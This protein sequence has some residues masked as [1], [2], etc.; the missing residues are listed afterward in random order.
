[1]TPVKLAVVIPTFNERENVQPLLARL[2][3]ALA[4]IRHEVIFVDDDSPDGTAECIREIA[5]QRSDVRVVQ[6]IGRRGLGSACIEGMLASAAP[7]IAV[8]DADMQ[9]DERILPEMFRKLVGENLDLVVGS[10]NLETG[11][12]GEF[13]R[14]RVML[15]NAGRRLSAAATG[16]QMSDPMSGFFMLDRR[17]LDEVVHHAS[18]VG[19]K[20]LLDLVASARRPVRIGEVPYTFRNRLHGESKLDISVGLEYL[21]LLADKMIGH[22]IPVRFVMFSLVGA[23]GLGLYLLVLGGLYQ[24]LG[25]DFLESL[26]A[27]TFLAMTLNF[28][29][30]NSFTYRDMKLKGF[31]LVM[32]LALFYVAC[33]IGAVSNAQVAQSLLASSAPWWVAA[34][35]GLLISAV[36][37]YGVTSIFTWRIHQVRTEARVQAQSQAVKAAAARAAA[38]QG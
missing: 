11:G 12:M 6:R 35:V 36:W 10:R 31:R 34:T 32:G 8:M 27:A 9:H 38:G 5:R 22:I 15:S 18:G 2:D 26:L 19:F 7:Y 29:L 37:N 3:D 20:I 16:C 21:Y 13:A 33:G 4:G 14:E 17:F 25:R 1:M 24:K 23:V 30:N 28:F